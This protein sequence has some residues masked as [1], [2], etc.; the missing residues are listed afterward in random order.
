M[1]KDEKGLYLK[2]LVKQKIELRDS[3]DKIFSY[4]RFYDLSNLVD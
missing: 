3:L 2:D 1:K 4:E